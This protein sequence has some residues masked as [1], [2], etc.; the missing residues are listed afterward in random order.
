MPGTCALRGAPWAVS[1]DVWARCKPS[2]LTGDILDTLSHD[3]GAGDL[4]LR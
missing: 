2:L 3:M 4:L 1:R